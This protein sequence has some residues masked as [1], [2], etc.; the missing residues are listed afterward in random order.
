LTIPAEFKEVDAF[1]DS[2]AIVYKG[3]RPFYIDRKGLTRI[4]GPFREATPFV[5]GLAA[6]LL[7]EKLVAY[8]DR[9]GK[10][11]FKYFRQ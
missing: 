4:A 9:N 5:H 7:T 3:G 11:I 10:T 2:L 1:S 6:V 8:I